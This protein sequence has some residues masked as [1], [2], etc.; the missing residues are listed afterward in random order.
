MPRG[1]PNPKP[2]AESEN[3]TLEDEE[4]EAREAGREHELAIQEKM[5]EAV[6]KANAEEL[7]KL[8]GNTFVPEDESQETESA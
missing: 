5:V 6:D 4:R 7:P 1:I 3:A 8:G 2:E